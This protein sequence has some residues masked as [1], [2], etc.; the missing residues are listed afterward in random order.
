MTLVA[1]ALLLLLFWI[2][3]SDPA[4]LVAGEVPDSA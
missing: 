3:A 1:A 2:H 4:G